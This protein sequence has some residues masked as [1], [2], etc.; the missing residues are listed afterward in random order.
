MLDVEA[1]DAASTIRL[2][3]R[4]EAVYPLLVTSHVFLDNV[5]YHHAVLVQH[6]LAQPGRRIKLRFIPA[7]CPHLNPIERL[8]GVMHKHLTH[9]KCYATYRE[10][11]EATLD[12]LREDVPQRWPEFRDSVTDNFLIIDPKGFRVMPCTG[13]ISKCPANLGISAERW[14]HK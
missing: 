1:V 14:M 2:L 5:R 11:A 10:F 4:M 9:N 8:W 3:E 7:Y 13:Y 12:F 6:W